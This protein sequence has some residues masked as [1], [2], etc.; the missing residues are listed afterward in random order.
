MD[1]SLWWYIARAGGLT[2]WWLLSS[3]VVWGLLT[4]TRI[5]SARTPHAT[6]EDLHRWLAGLAVAFVGVHLVALLVDRW[7][8]FGLPDL[9]VPFAS[10]YRPGAVAWGVVALYVLAAVQITSIARRHLPSRWWRRVPWATFALFVLVTVHAF[11]AGTDAGNTAIRV[12]GIL[13]GAAVLFLTTYRVLVRRRPPGSRASGARAAEVAPRFH[14]A[15]VTDVRAE[16]DDTVSVELAPPPSLSREFRF[17]PGQH[18]LVRADIEGH[19]VQRAYSLCGDSAKQELRIA[20]KHQPGG[21][22]SALINTRVRV[23]DTLEISTPAGLFGTTPDPQRSRHVL[24]V[25]AGSGITPIISLTTSILSAEPGSRVTLLYGNR[26]FASVIF[27]DELVRLS[28]HYT[29]RL[30][31]H[32]LLSREHPKP[33]LRHGRLTPDTLRELA[34]EGALDTAAIDE[35]FVCGPGAMVDAVRDTLRALGL[36]STRIQ[37]ERFPPRPAPVTPWPTPTTRDEESSAQVTVVLGGVITDVAARG[38][39]TIL[40]AALRDGLDVPY[41]CRTGYCFTCRGRLVAGGTVTVDGEP[42]ETL[43]PGA[44]LACQSRP[45]AERLVVD[46]DHTG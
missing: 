30:T 27:R 8:G 22:L 31:V 34:A 37:T 20:V 26:T 9:V 12:T 15:T 36:L 42:A 39:D 17:R 18:L 38:S 14:P 23:G 25:A 11:T 3:A 1:S 45:V 40:D 46:F 4:S 10:T 6:L 5:L 13:L 29:G 7:I 41:S 19:R 2:A 24:A 44:I 16:T 28:E 32:H 33:P 43:A 21:E 35:A